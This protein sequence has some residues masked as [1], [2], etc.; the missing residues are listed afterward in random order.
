LRRTGRFNRNRR[1]AGH[2]ARAFRLVEDALDVVGA[3][4]CST[5]RE[6]HQRQV[7]E[8]LGAVAF[9]LI[10]VAVFLDE[11]P[12]RS[13]CQRAHRH[14]I[15]ERAGRHEDRAFL[16]QRPRERLFELLHHAAERIG[17]GRH[18][19]LV[20]E[21][22]EQARVLRWREPESVAA[23]TNEAIVRFSRG[24]GPGRD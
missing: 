3:K 18:R 20:E 13:R 11:H 10:E 5:T 19:L 6:R 15:R 21:T 1:H 2:D 7:A 8:R 24:V 17:I 22:R 16:L 9:V 4:R 23:E 14:V 12:A